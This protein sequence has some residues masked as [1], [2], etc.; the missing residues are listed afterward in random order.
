M[1]L[2]NLTDD[3]ACVYAC[4]GVLMLQHGL[5]ALR[6]SM[7]RLAGSPGEGKPN[8]PLNR[9][10]EQQ[11]LHAEWAPVGA[12]LGLALMHKGHL[13]PFYR[14]CLVGSFTLSRVCFSA[15]PL[16]GLPHIVDIVSMT[17]CYLSTIA[18]AALLIAY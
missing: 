15:T 1:G 8:S 9:F 5:M 7:Y 18:M 2:G 17:A 6:M 4:I 10:S 11:L 3:G 12:I 14:D 13:P 16:L